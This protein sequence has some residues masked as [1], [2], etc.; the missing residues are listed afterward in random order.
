[1]PTHNFHAKSDPETYARMA[2]PHPNLDALADSAGDFLAGVATLREQHG[3][4]NVIVIYGTPVI[5][6]F[7]NVETA[8]SY[9]NWG[10]SGEVLPLLSCMLDRESTRVRDFIERTLEDSVNKT[11]MEDGPVAPH[12][13]A[14]ATRILQAASKHGVLNV[15]PSDKQTVL[16]LEGEPEIC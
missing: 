12:L 8:A 16:P 2:E 4:L 3:L 10:N 15:P 9:A 6:D 13:L 14:A 1:M 7:G 11:H 5:D